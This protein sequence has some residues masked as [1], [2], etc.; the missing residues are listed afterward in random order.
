MKENRHKLKQKVQTGCKE[1]L[2]HCEESQALEQ[3][4]WRSCAISILEYVQD[5]PR[6][7]SGQPDLM[8]L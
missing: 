4:G 1:K 6:K 3:I 2:F 8:L 5:L 7:C